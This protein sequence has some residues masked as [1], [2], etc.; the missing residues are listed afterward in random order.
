MCLLGNI[1]V[2]TKMF[3]YTVMYAYICITVN[4]HRLYKQLI[5]YQHESLHKHTMMLPMATIIPQR[6]LTRSFD[7][8]FDVRLNKRLSKQSWV[9]WFETPSRSLWR[10]CND[11]THWAIWMAIRWGISKKSRLRQRNAYG[12]RRIGLCCLS[13]PWYSRNFWPLI[14]WNNQVCCI[15]WDNNRI[16]C[17]LDNRY[18]CPYFPFCVLFCVS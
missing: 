16:I 11:R 17:T 12:A 18:I 9:W 10:H 8:F 15:N 5:A 4:I 13:E 2:N 14:K 3:N 6:P 7:V 1:P